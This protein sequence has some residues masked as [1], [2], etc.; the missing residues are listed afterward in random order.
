MCDS[1]VGL[2][3]KWAALV[4][5][6]KKGPRQPFMPRTSGEGGMELELFQDYEGFLLILY[7]FIYL[8]MLLTGNTSE[9]CK[10]VGVCL[11]FFGG[12]PYI[13]IA[14]ILMY[15]G[16][17]KLFACFYQNNHR[18]P[19][20]GGEPCISQDIQ[21]ALRSRFASS[22]QLPSLLEL[23]ALCP[24]SVLAGCRSPSTMPTPT[25]MA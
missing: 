14:N 1:V 22:L 13:Y 16:H 3:W 12:V 5:T 18:I 24:W 9:F 17:S 8:F 20:S 6:C 2:E 15:K 21:L 23:S 11:F 4:L 10:Q 25:A 19:T 7:I